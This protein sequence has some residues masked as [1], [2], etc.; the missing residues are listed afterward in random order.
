MNDIKREIFLTIGIPTYSREESV[1]EL[2]DL[3]GETKPDEACEVLVIN[4]GA[5]FDISPQIEKLSSLG[6]TVRYLLNSENCGGQENCLRIYENARGKYVWYIG[7]D[8]RFHI[9]AFYKVLEL[10]R[11]NTPDCML[12]NADTPGEVVPTFPTGPISERDVF[13]SQFTLGR[14]ICA[15]LSVIRR[16]AVISALPRARLFLGCFA[17]QFLLI[18]LGQVQNYFYLSGPTIHNKDVPVT[19]NQ[20]LSI[21]PIFLGIGNLPNI[22][23]SDQKTRWVRRLLKKE[24][25]VLN[26]PSHVLGALAIE[27]INGQKPAY[28]PYVSAGFRNYPL[29]LALIFS[30]ALLVLR[31]LP[32]RPLIPLITWYANTVKKRAID[33]TD[34]RSVD[35][36]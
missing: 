10:L 19:R 6:Y 29:L 32:K 20:K 27:E 8:D 12:V 21:L 36:I 30:L 23:L 15:P 26:S 9:E 18:L 14:L 3:L 4:N 2:L 31:L 16:E 11:R 28:L 22:G 35:R 1:V 7:D 25:R 13:A 33:I 17:P 5:D 34:F 24:W